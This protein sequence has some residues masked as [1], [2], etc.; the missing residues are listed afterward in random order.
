MDSSISASEGFG[1]FVSSAAAVMIV[2]A[3]IV[4]PYFLTFTASVPAVIGQWLLRIT[5]AAAFAVQQST[6]QYHQVQAAYTGGLGNG[7][8]PLA[9]WAGLAVLCGWAGLALAAAACLLRRR[10]A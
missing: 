9:G 1:A 4:V 8:F 7:F 2:I 5:P 3:A 10:D 6:P